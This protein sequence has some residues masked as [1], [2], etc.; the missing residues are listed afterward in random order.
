MKK[1]LLLSCSLTFMVALHAQVIHVPADYPTIQQGINAAAPGDTVLVAEGIYYEQINF[2]G[3]KPLMVASQFLSDGDTSH[4]S[5]T[6]L[7]GSQLTNMASASLVSFV[8]GEDSTSVLCGFTI[9]H[10]KGTVYTS[11]GSTYREGGGIFISSSGA[12]IIHNHIT[13]NHISNVISGDAQTVCGAGIGSEWVSGTH[14]VVVSSNIIDQN[15]CTS[16]D[17][18]AGGAG[19]NMYYNSRITGNTISGNTC[20][21]TGNSNAYA[22]GI[23]CSTQEANLYTITAFVDDNVIQNNLATSQNNQAHSS[24]VFFAAVKGIFSDNIVENNEVLSSPNIFGGCAV[25]LW[26]PRQG[27]VVHQH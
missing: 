15:S 7:D 24:G 27:S 20:T 5:N 13:E 12:K 14:W 10:G 26:M 25:I 22:A 16:N 18:G 19:I 1:M 17:V 23:G 8:S 2:E 6:I 11:L 9:R 3:K 4:I 21:G